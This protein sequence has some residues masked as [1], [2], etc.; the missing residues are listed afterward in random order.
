M[1]LMK[2]TERSVTLL[3]SRTPAGHEHLSARVTTDGDVLIEGQDLGSG[4]VAFWG[5]GLSEYEYAHRIASSDVPRLIAALG[6]KRG[7]DVLALLAGRFSTAKACAGITD[8]LRDHGIVSEFWN[9]V[10]D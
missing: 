1:G 7:A 9:R 3:D 5:S 10:G 8:F 2:M 6:G 4:V